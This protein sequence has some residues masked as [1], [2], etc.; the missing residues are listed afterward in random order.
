MDHSRKKKGNSFMQVFRVAE[1]NLLLLSTALSQT[2]CYIT[3]DVCQQTDS[4]DDVRSRR[5]FVLG[6]IIALCTIGIITDLLL[7]GRYFYNSLAGLIGLEIIFLLCV[8][9]I[10]GSCTQLED[11][12]LTIQGFLM[13]S[14]QVLQLFVLPLEIAG[15]IRDKVSLWEL[16]LAGQIL[17]VAM[18]NGIIV[19]IMVAPFFDL[20]YSSYLP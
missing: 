2:S 9:F 12:S 17:G 7:K 19:P 4:P 11:Y 8:L 14:I 6:A 10:D 5:M 18:I 1:Y 15:R 3:Y 20:I 13:T 16:P